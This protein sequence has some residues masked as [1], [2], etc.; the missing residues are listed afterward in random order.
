[1][2]PRRTHRRP[3]TVTEIERE[4]RGM[5]AANPT[6]VRWTA[7]A[8]AKHFTSCGRPV[9]AHVVKHVL[10]KIEARETL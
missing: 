3:P 4:L 5:L 10:A 7:D 6:V 2:K 1:M 9:S 8:W